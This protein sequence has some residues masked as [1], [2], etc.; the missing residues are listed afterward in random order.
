M[1]E[2]PTPT[3]EIEWTCPRCEGVFAQALPTDKPFTVPQCP[4]CLKNSRPVLCRG[5]QVIV[6]PTQA[7]IPQPD[8]VDLFNA[9]VLLQAMLDVAAARSSTG[10]PIEAFCRACAERGHG[11]A[12]CDC[13]CH[14]ARAFVRK[15][16]EP[17]AA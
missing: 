14:V 17:K 11:G 8:K 16:T 13:M 2:T 3:I 4:T 12:R 9:F 10:S 6:S 1:S 7:R 5:G 15:M